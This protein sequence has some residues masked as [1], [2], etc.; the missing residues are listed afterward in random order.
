MALMYLR[1]RSHINASMVLTKADHLCTHNYMRP[2]LDITLKSL[3]LTIKC[4]GNYR[5]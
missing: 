5:D 4:N 1:R 3:P 2:L